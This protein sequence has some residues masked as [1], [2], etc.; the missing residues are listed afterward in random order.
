[1]EYVNSRIVTLTNSKQLDAGFRSIVSNLK[2]NTEFYVHLVIN[3]PNQSDKSRTVLSRYIRGIADACTDPQ[4]ARQ[5]GELA[6]HYED[7]LDKAAPQGR[8]RASQA[9]GSASPSAD[10]HFELA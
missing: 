9:T 10:R 1:M 8:R 7:R 6:R 2:V 3:R 5:L 4:L